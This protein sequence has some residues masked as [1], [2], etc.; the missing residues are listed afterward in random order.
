MTKESGGMAQ[1][2]LSFV[3]WDITPHCNLNCRHCYATSLYRGNQVELSTEEMMCILENLCILPVT[4]IGMFGGEP[5]LRKDLAQIIQQCAIKNSRPYVITNGLLL[6]EERLESLIEAG[7]KGI[8]V[9]IDG[10]SKETY[11]YIRRGSDFDEVTRNVSGI[12]THALDSLVMDVV[13]SKLNVDEIPTLIKMAKNMGFTRVILEML[14]YQGNATTMERSVILSPLEFI[15]LAET[16]VETL[17]ELDMSCEFVTM[18]FA[19][20]PLIEHLNEKYGIHLPLEPKKCGATT[21][22]L[23]IRADGTAYPCKG[24]IPD[25]T[26]KNHDVYVS[27]GSSLLENSIIDILGSED[28]ERLFYMQS[29]NM[30]AEYLPRCRECDFFPKICVPCP[31]AAMDP[32]KKYAEICEDY[33]VGRICEEITCMR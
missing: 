20:P 14:S 32:G 25:M 12:S 18:L 23:F 16:V 21:S 8:A 6:T 7:L 4:N 9:S 19:M 1:G 3:D 26:L 10:A 2:G 30:I 29:P 33:P 31:I 27:Y 22:T 17:L 15:H 13:V 24:A 28:F 11:S 5:L